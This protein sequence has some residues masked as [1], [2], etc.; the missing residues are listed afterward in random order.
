MLENLNIG[1][2]DNQTHFSLEI[3][4]ISLLNDVFD[5]DQDETVF[6]RDGEDVEK[7]H[8]YI[9]I[10]IFFAC[11]EI[12]LSTVFSI[13]ILHKSVSSSKKVAAYKMPKSQLFTERVAESKDGDIFINGVYIGKF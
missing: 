2:W 5:D 10:L 7:D 8:G 13:M 11:L 4:E 6:V 12:V 9:Y 3:E 1:L